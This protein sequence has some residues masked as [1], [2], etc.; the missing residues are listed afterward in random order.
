[1][2]GVGVASS[3]STKS[4]IVTMLVTRR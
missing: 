4:A 1:M 3:G 2:T